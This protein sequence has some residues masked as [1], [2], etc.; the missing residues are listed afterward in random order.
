M[1][2][3]YNNGNLA[4]PKDAVIEEL[5]T[6]ELESG[7]FTRTFKDLFPRIPCASDVVQG[8]TGNCGF[9]ASIMM[10]AKREDAAEIIQGMMKD[11]Y[12]GR[13]VVR[14]Y[15]SEDKAHY[16]QIPKKVPVDSEKQPVS[17]VGAT[18]V[19]MLETAYVAF[20]KL[21]LK[22][23]E[24]V[25]PEVVL[26]MFLGP[27]S[28]DSKTLKVT[29]SELF[30][31]MVDIFY[32]SPDNYEL[33]KGQSSAA[34]RFTDNYPRLK[35]EVFG[36]NEDSLKKWITWNT[37][38]TRSNAHFER[39]RQQKKIHAIRRADFDDWWLQLGPSKNDLSPAVASAV[40]QWIDKGNVLPGKR[41]TGRY[42]DEQLK[43]FSAME[44]ALSH[45]QIVNAATHT[46]FW[47][48][49]KDGKKVAE[50][51]G[52]GKSG[53]DA[54]Q[55]IFAKHW[56]GIV[57]V[58]KDINGICFVKIRNPHGEVGRAYNSS[59]KPI[60]VDGAAGVESRLELSD[61]TKLAEEVTI[62]GQRFAKQV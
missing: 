19:K 47:T 40:V 9:M 42:S 45:R 48:K 32:I 5:N 22:Q 41:F 39:Y 20:K 18:W 2:K 61:F 60:R 27:A 26:R 59:N 44:D 58:E 15:D 55:G 31:I 49:Y 50:D 8:Q 13:V 11:A 12:C 1:P 7:S 10:L 35:D 21:S 51:A 54:R 28:G 6:P 36:G 16:I 23:I 14:V 33:P 24:G 37:N 57:S 62:N 30:E 4:V 3:H 43:L 17:S 38:L 56:Y 29:S 34:K 25:S 53:E 52:K 46:S